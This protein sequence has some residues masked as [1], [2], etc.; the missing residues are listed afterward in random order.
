MRLTRF[1]RKAI[2]VIAGILL[3]VN[4]GLW[5]FTTPSPQ[6]QKEEGGLQ[7]TASTPITGK[8]R[9][10]GEAT[11]PFRFDPN[12]AD[13]ATFVRLGLR[14]RVARAIVHY[15]AAGGVFRKPQDLAR[16][17]TLSDSDY[18]R[19]LPYINIKEQS[20]HLKEQP[21]TPLQSSLSNNAASEPYLPMQ[22]FKL[23]AGQT[24][25]I[26]SADSV[27][28]RKI[29]GV[30]QYYAAKIVKYRSRLG[31]FTSTEQL[32][33]IKGLPDDITR[34][35]TIGTEPVS[36]LAV[37]QLTFGQL[38]RHP[39]LNFEQVRAIMDHRKYTGPI[40]NLGDLR[41]YPAFSDSDF[42][43]LQPYIAFE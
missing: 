5:I 38:L 2:L 7:D 41:T 32:K 43:R 29:P 33:E 23:Q 40:H 39:Y 20:A 16:I 18:R 36:K 19:L 10:E 14:P 21:P 15:R 35:V 25:D 17:Y 22:S 6:P 26:N 1:D 8:E 9:S 3:L 4:L 27:E 24:L 34:W 42:R 12:T 37:N 28:L 31:G 30:G 11:T 13:S